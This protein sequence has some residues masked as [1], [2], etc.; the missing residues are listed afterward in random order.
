MKLIRLCGLSVWVLPLFA[1]CGGRID[2]A[3]VVLGARAVDFDG[4][5][6][7][8]LPQ[9]AT[10]E[11][12][13]AP[14]LLPAPTA[15]GT[16]VSPASS[17]CFDAAPIAAFPAWIA[18][19]PSAGCSF[20]FEAQPGS[21]T[22]T[23]NCCDEVF[24][25]TAFDAGSGMTHKIWTASTKPG[26]LPEVI[27]PDCAEGETC[28]ALPWQCPLEGYGAADGIAAGLAYTPAWALAVSEHLIEAPPEFLDP[29]PIGCT[30]TAATDRC[31]ATLSCAEHTYYAG[32]DSTGEVI[33]ERDGETVTPKGYADMVDPRQCVP[34]DPVS[35]PVDEC[36]GAGWNQYFWFAAEGN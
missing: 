33:C 26:P 30:Y 14:T 4:S 6:E 10:A 36:F 11:A 13:P 24:S 7:D 34:G 5:S 2:V 16:A 9:A 22:A 12:L 19:V 17:A 35:I 1:A 21:C 8:G 20:Q 28:D 29:V 18:P 23:W 3:E 32:S 25:V 15:V 27:S 31:G